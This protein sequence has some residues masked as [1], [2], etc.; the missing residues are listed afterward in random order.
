MSRSSGSASVCA[1]FAYVV[2]AHGLHL[3]AP[4]AVLCSGYRAHMID[5]GYFTR[6]YLAIS[7][8]QLRISRE[9]VRRRTDSRF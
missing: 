7:M 2:I 4:S 1:K 3:S 5:G 6:V 9:Q 8:R